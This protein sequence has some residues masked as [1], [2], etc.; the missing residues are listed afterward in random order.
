MGITIFGCAEDEAALFREMAPRLGVVPTITEA[1]VS[2]TNI[3]LALGNRC[4]SIGHKTQVTNSTLLALSEA[5]VTYI[6]TRSVGY[7]HIDVNYAESVG[8]SVETVAYSPDSVA[9]YTLMLMLMAVRHA[10]SVIRRAD[11][12]DYRLKMYVGKSY[13]T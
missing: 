13:A 6:S 4:I 3:D 1:A 12:H 2:E 5:G 9:D 7:N 11:V 8:I 10:K